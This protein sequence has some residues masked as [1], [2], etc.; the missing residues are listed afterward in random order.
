MFKWWTVY[1]GEGKQ[2][3][4]GPIR[5]TS[6]STYL[7]N[8]VTSETR[9]GSASCPWLIRVSHS[10]AVNITLIDFTVQQDKTTTQDSGEVQLPTCPVYAEM[11]IATAA[12]PTIICSRSQ[13]QRVLH[14]S[15]G[16]KDIRIAV[17]SARS[18]Q[19]DFYFLLRVE[20]EHLAGTVA[21]CYYCLICWNCCCCC[22][23]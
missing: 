15:T 22:C 10:Q 6:S 8:I 1:E 4:N 11:Y 12:E 21:N 16:R 23:R 19:Q 5:V 17:R 13:R 9:R 7:A 14:N 3:G 2:C 18:S 20:G